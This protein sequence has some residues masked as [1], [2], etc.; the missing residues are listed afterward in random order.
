MLVPRVSKFSCVC[1]RLSLRIIVSPVEA[2]LVKL[3]RLCIVVQERI[4]SNLPSLPKSI[5]RLVSGLQTPPKD[6]QFSRANYAHLFDTLE[7][8]LSADDLTQQIL[9]RSQHFCPH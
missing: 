7:D 8:K 9:S 1:N 2:S 6:N 3:R 4:L 5:E